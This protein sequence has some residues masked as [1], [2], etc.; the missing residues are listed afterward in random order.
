MRPYRQD[1]ASVHSHVSARPDKYLS[2]TLRILLW[3]WLKLTK[4]NWAWRSSS[5][6]WALVFAWEYDTFIKIHIVMKHRVRYVILTGC[7]FYTSENISLT[8]SAIIC[9]K[10]SKTLSLTAITHCIMPGRDLIH[11]NKQVTTWV[12]FLFG[13]CLP[14]LSFCIAL[15]SK[16]RNM[17]W[18]RSESGECSILTIVEKHNSI[19][20]KL[21]IT[22]Q[23]QKVMYPN[24]HHVNLPHVLQSVNWQQ[25]CG[26]GKVQFVDECSHLRRRIQKV[27]DGT[28]QIVQLRLKFNSGP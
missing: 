18:K 16:Y 5:S 23:S 15:S 1:L 26:H 9:R 13:F 7:E 11:I 22:E 14:D 12:S 27:D 6:S 4:R 28:S 25:I 20:V 21:T 10:T 8:L 3:M 24:R 17:T 19:K 2:A